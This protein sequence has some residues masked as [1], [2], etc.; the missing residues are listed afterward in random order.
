ME[1]QV[2]QIGATHPDETTM[3][4]PVIASGA[5]QSRATG[6]RPWIASFRSQ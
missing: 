4:P 2:L 6:M 5:N 3:N 1:V